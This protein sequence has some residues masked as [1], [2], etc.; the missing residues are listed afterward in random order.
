LVLAADFFPAFYCIFKN[1]FTLSYCLYLFKHVNTAV[2]GKLCVT[3]I[4]VKVV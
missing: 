1:L 3:W 2:H 4:E